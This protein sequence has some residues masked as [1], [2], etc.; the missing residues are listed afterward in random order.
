[1]HLKSR[2]LIKSTLFSKLPPIKLRKR[3]ELQE[4]GLR[5]THGFSPPFNT[6]TSA[7]FYKSLPFIWEI[8][9]SIGQFPLN[10]F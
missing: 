9:I 2:D 1:M 4:A 6:H 8:F 7:V 10:E 3:N 5:P